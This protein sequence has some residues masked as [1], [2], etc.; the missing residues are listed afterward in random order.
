MS[1]MVSILRTITTNL[2]LI[3]LCT[4]TSPVV[5]RL[6]VNRFVRGKSTNQEWDRNRER[7]MASVR[8]LRIPAIFGQ[9]NLSV[10]PCGDGR[11]FLSLE[12]ENY[13]N[14]LFF[15]SFVIFL[16]SCLPSLILGFVFASR[17]QVYIILLLSEICYLGSVPISLFWCFKF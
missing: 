12:R 3:V 17:L 16:F 14:V 1:C 11:C 2:K 10:A 5:C 13:L 6:T 9:G 8:P 15:W 4:A 7:K